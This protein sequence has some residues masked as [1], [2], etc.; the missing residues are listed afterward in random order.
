MSDPRI[1]AAREALDRLL[2]DEDTR[3]RFLAE[4]PS[5][6]GVDEQTA[7]AFGAVD[8]LQLESSARKISSDLLARK[9]RGSPGLLE[10]YAATLGDINVRESL[11]PRF[12]ASRHY[13]AYRE[14]SVAG[15]PG[16]C[17]E[18]A[19]YRF[20]DEEEVGAPKVRR[21]EFLQALFRALAVQP[22]PSFRVPPE[23]RRT[24]QGGYLLVDHTPEGPRLYAVARGRLLF[25]PLTPLLAR[26]LEWARP[27]ERS[28]PRPDDVTDPRAWDA[29]VQKLMALGLLA[30]PAHPDVQ[31]RP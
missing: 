9:H 28:L 5:A 6:L 20:L 8:P 16:L 23:V 11:L 14:L 10:S 4:G 18:E 22:R 21:G 7:E 26:V 31:Q 27:E 13:A 17:I 24:A 2:H 25:G 15:E 12:V 30:A 29:C 19:F 1:R 3:R